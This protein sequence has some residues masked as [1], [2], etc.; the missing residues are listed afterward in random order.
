[1]MRALVV[2]D[3]VVGQIVKTEKAVRDDIVS[4]IQIPVQDHQDHLAR[5]RRRHRHQ[6]WLNLHGFVDAR[7]VTATGHPCHSICGAV[8]KAAPPFGQEPAMIRAALL[9]LPL[10]GI[11][12]DPAAA[13]DPGQ[14]DYMVRMIS[15][16]GTDANMEVYLPQ[17]VVLNNKLPLARALAK[18]VLGYYTLDLSSENKGKSLEPIRVSMTADGNTMIVNQYTRKLPPTRIPVA[19]GIVDFDQRFG[20]GAKCGPFESQDPNFQ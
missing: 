13:K 8:T 19:G 12:S 15:C 16:T 6:A 3:S 9:A 4:Q 5:R 7:L 17:S 20:T 1:M 2:R 18:P 10:L 14:D 11:I